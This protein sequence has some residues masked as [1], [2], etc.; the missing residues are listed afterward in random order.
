MAPAS[1]RRRVRGAHPRRACNGRAARG[2][3]RERHPGGLAVG[4]PHPRLGRARTART[5]AFGARIGGLHP[6][7]SAGPPSR[8]SPAPRPRR[9]PSPARPRRKPVRLLR[10]APE[11][12]QRPALRRM[13]RPAPEPQ[14][15]EEPEAEAE[16]ESV[17]EALAAEFGDGEA[18]VA[19]APRSFPGTVDAVRGRP[20]GAARERA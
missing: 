10:K 5:L 7:P 14:L 16:D 1:P 18:A 11:P 12:N 15:V 17:D 4:G 20:R 3:R 9:P 19:C 6:R 13:E 8:P 2:R